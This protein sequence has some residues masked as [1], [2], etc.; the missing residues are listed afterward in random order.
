MLLD[1]TKLF[2]K[3][4]INV[5]YYQEYDV[6][7]ILN[8]T[9]KGQRLVEKYQDSQLPISIGDRS[10]ITK[11]VVRNVLV[12]NGNLYPSRAAKEMI[13]SAILLAFPQMIFNEDGVLSNCYGL[14]ESFFKVLRKPPL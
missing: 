3:A 2:V 13:A 9:V 5:F 14:I 10:A 6:I 1:D 7:T 12:V 8:G 4:F 11:L